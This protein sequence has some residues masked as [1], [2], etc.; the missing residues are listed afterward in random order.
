MQLIQQ[1]PHHTVGVDTLLGNGPF[2][3][4][5]LQARWD[6]LILAL[7]QQLGMSALIKTMEISAFHSTGPWQLSVVSPT[8]ATAAEITVGQIKGHCVFEIIVT[9]APVLS[10]P[11]IFTWGGWGGGGQWMGVKGK[12][13]DLVRVLN[14]TFY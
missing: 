9:S 12:G 13:E 10:L 1:D 5:D 2:C 4:P 7:A 6:P 11:A 8:P 14:N 3:N